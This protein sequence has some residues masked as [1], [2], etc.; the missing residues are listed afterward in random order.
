MWRRRLVLV[1][2]LGSEFKTF[3]EIVDACV[4]YYESNVE[5]MRIDSVHRNRIALSG[6]VEKFHSDCGTLTPEV[7]ERINALRGSECIVVMS[8][9]QPNLFAYSGVMRKITLTSVLAKELEK[10]LDVPVVNF[11]GIAD[12]DFTDDRWVKSSMLPAVLRRDGV[13]SIHISLPEK[14]LL[15]AVPNPSRAMLNEWKRLIEGWLDDTVGSVERL[16]ESCDSATL[17]SYKDVLQR[18]FRSFWGMV[19][20]AYERSNSYSD[21]NSFVMSKIV[22]E[23]WGYSTLFSRFSECQQVFADDINFLLSRYSDYSRFLEEAHELLSAKG[24][25]SGVSAEERLLIPFWYHCSCGSKVRLFSAQRNG[26]L[27]GYG[28]CEVCGCH[29]D[30]DLGTVAKPDVSKLASRLSLRAISWILAFSKGLGLSCY[31]GGIGGMWYIME[32]KHVADRLGISLPPIPVWRPHDRYLGIGQVEA[33]LKLKEMCTELGVSDLSAVVD[34]LKARIDVANV[35][36]DHLEFSKSSVMEKLQE[37]PDDEE[38]EKEVKRFSLSKTK[39]KKSSNL[40]VIYRKL[41]ILENIPVV[42][43]MIPSIIDYAVN[44]G[45][46][47]TSDQWARFLYENGDLFSDVHLKSILN[48]IK[49]LDTSMITDNSLLH[50]NKG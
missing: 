35:C 2:D 40:S 6:F 1:S 45:L 28:D 26:S 31:V 10:R 20:D 16:S 37:H 17:N 50:E 19:E 22:N 15:N 48:S 46:K 27:F 41:K 8:A 33:L 9:H 34:L 30:L 13:L 7:Q 29:Y 4:G 49:G 21:F 3:S 24:I 32:L 38:L 39:V 36:L 23:A 18:N 47:E 42:L 5:R 44:V 12:Q 43:A 14:I 11:F 25:S